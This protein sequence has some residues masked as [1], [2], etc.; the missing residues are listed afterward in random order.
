MLAFEF[1]VVLSETAKQ[2]NIEMTKEIVIKAEKLLEGECVT[3]NL[4]YNS[5]EGVPQ[6]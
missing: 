1:A 6:G 2:L 5:D 4:Y 3:D